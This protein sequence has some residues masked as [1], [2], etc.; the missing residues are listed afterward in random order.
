MGRLEEQTIVGRMDMI[1][2]LEVGV[3]IAQRLERNRFLLISTNT[4]VLVVVVVLAEFERKIVE[5]SA[6]ACALNWRSVI[7]CVAVRV[8]TAS[9]NAHPGY[10]A[11]GLAATIRRF[12]R[13]IALL[14]GLES[15]R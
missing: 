10:V 6:E 7:I 9:A 5:A 12:L 13:G 15:R 1:G 3:H 8:E 4:T 2:P 11:A 14:A